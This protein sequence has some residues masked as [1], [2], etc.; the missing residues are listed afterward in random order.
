M[1]RAVP[2]SLR[3][4]LAPLLLVLLAGPAG[5]RAEEA[6]PRPALCFAPGTPQETVDELQA[7]HGIDGLLPPGVAAPKHRLVTRWTA[8]AT[9]GGGLQYGQP[10]TITWSYVPDGTPLAGFAGEPSSP[11]NLQAWLDDLYGDFDTWHPIFVD[12]FERWSELTGN[13]YVY[14]PLDD[15]AG[16]PWAPGA[17]GRRGDVRIAGHR[18]DGSFGILAYNFFPDYGDMMMDTSDRWYDDTRQDS[19]GL[20][21]VLAHEHGHGLGLAH[22]CPVNRTKLMEPFATRA[23]RGPQ[24]DDIRGGQRGY[25]DP[26]EPSDSPT[27]AHA[28]GGAY[29]PGVAEELAGID[30]DADEDWYRIEGLGADAVNGGEISVRVT[31][32]GLTYQEGPQCR[33]WRPLDST[34]VRDLG[35]ELVDA[36]GSTV[37]ETVD[38]L[39]PGGDEELDAPLTAGDRFLRVFSAPGADVQLYDFEVLVTANP[40]VGADGPW[41]GECNGGIVPLAVDASASFDPDGGAIVSHEWSTSCPGGFADPAAAATTLELFSDDCTLSCDATVTV[42]DDEGRS[43]SE[44]FDV[45]LV[46]TQPPAIACPA[47]RLVFTSAGECE[48]PWPGFAAGASDACDPAPALSDDAPALL[49]RGTTAVRHSATDHCGLVD[50][51]T[52]LVTVVG[53]MGCFAANCSKLRFGSGR[54]DGRVTLRGNLRSCDGEQLYAGLQPSDRVRLVI[55]GFLEFDEPWSSFEEQGPGWRHR[56]GT[57]TLTLRGG[58]W[59]YSS[60]ESSLTPG[61]LEPADGVLHELWLGF[62]QGEESLAMEP[63]G[64][65]LEACRHGREVVDCP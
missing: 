44:T 60:R 5:V 64:E 43:W 58:S 2:T 19:R 42:T 38:A 17:V 59:R 50:S 46:D 7:A 52:Q 21:N 6:T 25:G 29:P 14:E 31:P 28:L 65:G 10:T 36:D 32:N 35:F 40:V 22:V 26:F 15:G 51:C 20:R 49:P 27:E 48:L 45:D 54:A 11:S 41:S 3:P 30:R 63:K 18:I 37:L 23:F 56:S 24:H 16:W 39:G 53:R 57:R 4:A 12:M 61:D 34:I 1:N 33:D 8:T 55:D 13:T 62:N 9:D 47:D